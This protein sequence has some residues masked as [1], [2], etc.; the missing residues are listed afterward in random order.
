MLAYCQYTVQGVNANQVKTTI[1]NHQLKGTISLLA[2]E[3]LRFM[4][5][6]LVPVKQNEATI[7]RMFV[8]IKLPVQKCDHCLQAQH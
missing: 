7:Q 1:Y 4:Q 2:P 5:K 6:E 8:K 3:Q